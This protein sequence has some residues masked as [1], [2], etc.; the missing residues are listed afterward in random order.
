MT[1]LYDDGGKKQREIGINNRLGVGLGGNRDWVF[2]TRPF[3]PP[4][5]LQAILHYTVSCCRVVYHSAMV[6]YFTTGDGNRGVHVKPDT[7]GRRPS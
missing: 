7:T 1:S 5:H 6:I 3:L 2:T 4:S